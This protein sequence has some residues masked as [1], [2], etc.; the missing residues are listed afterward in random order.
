MSDDQP[1]DLVVIGPAR[2]PRS[3]ARVSER[4][5]GRSPLSIISHSAA[6][7]RCVGAIRR[8]CSSAARKPSICLD[9]CAGG[10][11]RAT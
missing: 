2:L 3:Q 7:V 6:P 11:L 8:R 9:E 10:V 1:Y 4:Q 5:G